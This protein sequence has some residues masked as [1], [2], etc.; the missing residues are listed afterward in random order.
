[1]AIK[2]IG[3][4]VNTYGLKGMIKISI[5]TTEPEKRYAVG[6]KI[7]TENQMHE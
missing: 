7:L 5:S 6:K 3:H 2:K 4:I 1:M